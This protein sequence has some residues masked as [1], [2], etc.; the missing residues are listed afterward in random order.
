MKINRV[1]MA[2]SLKPIVNVIVLAAVAM[3]AFKLGQ[4]YQS[5]K[6][7]ESIIENQYAH[8]FSPKEVSIA[9]DEANELIIIERATGR[10]IVYSDTIG[11][12]IFG[13]Y[14][15]RIHQEVNASK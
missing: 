5:S 3:A 1:I 8:A 11:R 9:V 7:D 14:A 6:K 2:R 12:T 10:Y 13:M 4:T 15:N